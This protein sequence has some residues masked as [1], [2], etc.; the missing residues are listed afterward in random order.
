MTK[1]EDGDTPA[2]MD[3]SDVD[4]RFAAFLRALMSSEDMLLREADDGAAYIVIAIRGYNYRRHI[5]HYHRPQLERAEEL[6]LK[7]LPE[8][9][10]EPWLFGW[11][12][13]P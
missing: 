4:R 11:R 13:R 8:Y 3:I 9:Q 5:E 1:T 12:W 6:S 2:P 10:R 7:A